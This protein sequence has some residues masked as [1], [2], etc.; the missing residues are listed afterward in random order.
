MTKKEFIKYWVDSAEKDWV[1]SDV[2]YKGKSYVHALFFVHL[3]L[4]KLCKA[5][6][7][8]DHISNHPPRIHNLIYI[9]DKTILKPNIEQRAFLEKMNT[10][11]LEGRYPDYNNII[12]KTTDQI[13]TR[14]ILQKAKAIREWL[15]TNL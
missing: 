8:K 15:L 4:E 3:T 12:Y 13:F 14:D 9:I 2:L 1:A 5:H 7:V 11:Q 10:F 6:W